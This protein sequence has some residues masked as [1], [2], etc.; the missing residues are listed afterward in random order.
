[1]DVNKMLYSFYT[2]KKV[3]HV[4]VITTKKRF[5]GRNSQVQWR[6]NPLAAL[7]IARGGKI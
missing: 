5:L 3:P 7:A 4:M 2:T 6:S 1:M